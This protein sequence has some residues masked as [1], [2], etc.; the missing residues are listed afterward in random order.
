MASP[1][2]DRDADA[3]TSPDNDRAWM[4]DAL[5]LGDRARGRVS[6]NPAV[7]ALLVR[8][9]EVVGRGWTRPPGG[10]HAE[11][12]SLAEAGERACGATLYV[13]LEP[14]SHHGRT[15]PCADAVIS[16]GVARVVAAIAD[17]HPLV[18]GGGLD[19]LRAAG[20]DVEVGVE[21]AAAREAHAPFLHRLATGRPLVT[22]KYAAT[23]DGR[24]ATS[25]GESRWITGEDARLEA[26]RLRDR[27]AAI[28]VGAGTVVADDPLLT[29]RIPDAGHELHHPLRVVVDGRGRSPVSARI[30]DPALPGRTIVLTS[31]SSALPWR[32][33]LGA[34]GIELVTLGPGPR[35][36][37]AAI[38][39]H[40][41]E[42]GIDSLLVEGG[43][44]LL[45]GFFDAGAVDRV[46]A[47]VAPVIVG[48]AGAPG[49][50]AGTGVAA[51]RSAPRLAAVQVRRIGDDIVIDGRIAATSAG[52]VA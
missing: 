39:A 50:V 4:R 15:P 51:L 6:P 45:G 16:A 22:A 47:F 33:D 19:R 38:L 28:A 29:T 21:A 43:G 17:P 5:A 46:V 11:V 34:R 42:R 37:V 8:D 26:H 49:P 20:I 52:E 13:T 18:A 30:F 24:I 1:N 25:T 9:G 36:P 3:M 48:G 35:L 7:G 31:D 41:G 40:L 10:P 32:R 14:C 44:D 23:L 27:I 12:V 2:G